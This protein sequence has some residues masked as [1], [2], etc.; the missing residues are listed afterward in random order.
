MAGETSTLAKAIQHDSVHRFQQAARDASQTLNEIKLVQAKVAVAADTTQDL[1]AKSATTLDKVERVFQNVARLRAPFQVSAIEYQIT[2]SLSEPLF[3]EWLAR[4]HAATPADPPPFGVVRTQ[5]PHFADRSWM[6]VDGELLSVQLD[7][8]DT[9]LPRSDPAERDAQQ[10]LACRNIKLAL[11]AQREAESDLVYSL[12]DCDQNDNIAYGPGD[13]VVRFMEASGGATRRQT[14]ILIRLD[15][16]QLVKRI[17]V[18][19]PNPV[20]TT[21]RIRTIADLWSGAAA[22]TEEMKGQPIHIMDVKLYPDAS[23]AAYYQL[24]FG[25][26]AISGDGARILLSYG[27]RDNL[28]VIDVFDSPQSLEA[29][30]KILQPI[31]QQLGITAQADVQEAY[32]IIRG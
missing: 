9:L 20:Q 4:V 23:L 19:G 7:G 14:V 1:Q 2:Y 31:L 25:G 27:S 24:D 29:F 5:A 6:Y 15:E 21:G 32:K 16:R 11:Y 10:A 13:S 30:G 28:Q 3:T 22:F 8:H 12:G 26:Q 18:L 17:L